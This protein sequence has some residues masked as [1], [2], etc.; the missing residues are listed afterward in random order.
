[1]INQQEKWLPVSISGFEETYMISNFGRVIRKFKNNEKFL[2][3]NPNKD[4]YLTIMLCNK[5][6]K[7][8]Q[9]IHRMVAINFLPNTENKRTVNHIDGNKQNNH[10][11]NLEWATHSE[12]HIHA[13]R[14]LNRKPNTGSINGCYSK[15]SNEQ[16]KLII[17]SD[18][19]YSQLSKLYNISKGTVSRIKN[20]KTK[21]SKAIKQNNLDISI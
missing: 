17:N 16:V 20:K 8:C 1:M 3:G 12:N 14:K 5:N 11:D 2:P 19:S 7:N 15:L 6:N 18:L 21:Y 10:I 9:Y 13:F 4:G